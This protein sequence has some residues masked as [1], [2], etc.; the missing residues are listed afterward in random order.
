[1]SMFESKSHNPLSGASI[2]RSHVNFDLVSAGMVSKTA[3]GALAVLAGL[4]A[5]KIN[6]QAPE[7]AKTDISRTRT[8]LPTRPFDPND[9]RLFLETKDGRNVTLYYRICA[10]DPLVGDDVPGGGENLV[11][12]AQVPRFTAP[13]KKEGALTKIVEPTDQEPGLFSMTISHGKPEFCNTAAKI[14][15]LALPK[16]KNIEVIPT[17]ISAASVS[18]WKA[19]IVQS[20]DGKG[21]AKVE[22]KLVAEVPVDSGQIAEGRFDLEVLLTKD[23]AEQIGSAKK[24]FLKVKVNWLSTEIDVVGVAQRITLTQED[25]TSLQADWSQDQK[26]GKATISGAE[27][28]RAV[29]K[30][31]NLLTR[32]AEI[33]GDATIL[34]EPVMSSFIVNLF[35]PIALSAADAKLLTDREGIEKALADDLFKKPETITTK[36]SRTT[37]SSKDGSA[38]EGGWVTVTGGGDSSSVGISV[39]IYYVTVGM[40]AGWDSHYRNEDFERRRQEFEKNHAVEVTYNETTKRWEIYAKQEYVSQLHQAN[41][42]ARLND[43]VRQAIAA[44]ELRISSTVVFEAEGTEYAE[45]PRSYNYVYNHFRDNIRATEAEIVGLRQ[46]WLEYARER[47]ALSTKVG[48]LQRM[49]D[50]YE[51]IPAQTFSVPWS[52]DAG[53]D[54][55]IP[56]KDGVKLFRREWEL[57]TNV[58]PEGLEPR[59]AVKGFHALGNE[60]AKIDSL[61]TRIATKRNDRIGIING[62]PGFDNDRRPAVLE[63]H[64]QLKADRRRYADDDINA[65]KSAAARA[66]TDFGN[67]LLMAL[68]ASAT[69]E[70]PYKEVDLANLS[71]NDPAKT[72]KELQNYEIAA[73]AALERLKIDLAESGGKLAELKSRLGSLTGSLDPSSINALIDGIYGRVSGGDGLIEVANDYADRWLESVMLGQVVW[74]HK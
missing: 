50:S 74:P 27:Q 3:A 70:F 15:R 61:I 31:S 73:L 17:Q 32:R 52:K 41:V 6:A 67:S 21:S 19:I 25:L 16:N 2:D 53:K 72:I 68:Q 22:Y 7:G 39:P 56:R 26:I 12:M 48:N 42:T 57:E 43:L 29:H 37:D 55:Q 1:M 35:K 24:G 47:D 65:A 13:W 34:L 18:F 71:T 38:T 58:R 4:V 49:F 62:Y 51:F 64:A 59:E 8:G 10:K 54:A 28:R 23:Q 44:E 63:R 14:A 5:P 9:F 66:K 46:R 40:Q 30:I 36:G 60:A 11:K 69:T 20:N 33:W 45:T